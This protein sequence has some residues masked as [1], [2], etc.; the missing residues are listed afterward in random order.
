MPPKKQKV[1]QHDEAT[2]KQESDVETQQQQQQPAREAQGV[3]GVDGVVEALVVSNSRLCAQVAACDARAFTEWERA[4]VLE[5][6]LT[7]GKVRISVLEAEG[8]AKDAE[9]TRLQL[10]LACESSECSVKVA[11]LKA[12]V[13]ILKS[14]NSRL[15]LELM[16]HDAEPFQMELHFN[17]L[18]EQM[19]SAHQ[20]QQQLLHLQLLNIVMVGAERAPAPA[21]APDPLLSQQQQVHNK[22]PPAPPFAHITPC[23]HHPIPLIRLRR[24]L[25]RLSVCS[26]QGNA[27]L[28]QSN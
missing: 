26:R 18:L 9:T 17:R 3:V 10:Q 2:V 7:E 19:A 25:T 5:E 16:R 27:Q 22:I 11:E 20:Q 21:P 13:A 8:R 14:D 1:F 15:Q 24:V 12:R 28:Q 23:T 4:R 6:Q